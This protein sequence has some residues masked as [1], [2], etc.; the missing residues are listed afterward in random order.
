MARQLQHQPDGIR[1]FGHG[2]RGW[3]CSFGRL[4]P[5]LGNNGIRQI[6]AERGR[7]V[8]EQHEAKSGTYNSVYPSYGVQVGSSLL[9]FVIDLL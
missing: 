1:A 6:L 8:R 5:L 4:H 2:G 3:I 9:E 7:N